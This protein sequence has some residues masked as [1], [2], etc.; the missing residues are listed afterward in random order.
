MKRTQTSGP[1]HVI[2]RH[3]MWPHYR[4]SKPLHPAPSLAIVGDQQRDP[5]YFCFPS[6]WM[7]FHFSCAAE[8][9]P[10]HV[11]VVC[12]LV[13][14][15]PVP[16]CLVCAGTCIWVSSQDLT[17][18]ALCHPLD[19]HLKKMQSFIARTG[20]GACTWAALFAQFFELPAASCQIRPKKQPTTPKSMT[21]KNK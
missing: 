7:S 9:S 8:T 18:D 16:P 10:C 20:V 12:L 1:R 2:C 5:F 14:F 21:T 15:V 6:T 3:L 17:L 4:S 11:F 19:L 13:C